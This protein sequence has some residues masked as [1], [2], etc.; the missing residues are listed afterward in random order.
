MARNVCE[1]RVRYRPHTLNRMMDPGA[2]HRN[3]LVMRVQPDEALYMLTVAKEPGISTEQV[4]KQ[5]CM[6]MRYIFNSPTATWAT[7]TN[8]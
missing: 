6:D 1:L 2:E 3:E 8:A 5:V 7:R 4:R